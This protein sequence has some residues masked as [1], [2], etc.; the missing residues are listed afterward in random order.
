M[1]GSS[2]ALASDSP[3]AARILIGWDEGGQCALGL[4]LPSVLPVEG[5]LSLTVGAARLEIA[6]DGAF[7]LYLSDIALKAL[8]LI[9]LPPNGSIQMA[10]R[11]GGWFASYIQDKKTGG[12]SYE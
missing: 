5:V 7:E 11:E 3:I 4:K 1:L 2:G 6:E 10:L 9:K 12:M 8:G